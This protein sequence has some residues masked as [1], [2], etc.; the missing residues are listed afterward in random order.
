MIDENDVEIRVKQVL[1]T[2]ANKPTMFYPNEGGKTPQATR[3]SYHIEVV[4]LW[5]DP[6][7]LTI[8]GVY[9]RHNFAAMCTIVG[10]LNRGTGGSSAHVT[11]LKNLFP[12]DG[13]FTTDA[14]STIR[15]AS[16][17]AK[18][19]G[20]SDSKSWRVPVYVPLQVMQN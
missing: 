7:R 18:R 3:N 2:M 19:N 11:S 1:E 17:P 4:F 15:V 5:V 16:E 20:F 6:Q 13:K 12:A 14:G 8:S 9:H 10:P